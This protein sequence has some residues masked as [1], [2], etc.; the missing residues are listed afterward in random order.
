MEER[1]K[2]A[3]VSGIGSVFRLY[4]YHLRRYPL[5]LIP[6]F[7]GII[8]LQVGEL[9]QP[10]FLRKFFNILATHSPDAQIVSQ[11][12]GIIAILAGLT[13]ANWA[14][15]RIQN[16]CLQYLESWVMADLYATAFEYLIRHSYNFF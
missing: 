3:H 2:S 7:V 15:R 10:I 6:L 16:L 5:I 14:M 12:S 1:K 4:Y 8:G 9:F 13:I 11:L